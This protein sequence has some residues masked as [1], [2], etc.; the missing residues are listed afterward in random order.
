MSYNSIDVQTAVAQTGTA[1][2]EISRSEPLTIAAPL[3]IILATYVLFYEGLLWSIGTDGW[4]GIRSQLPLLDKLAESAGAYTHYEIDPE[5]ETVGVLELD[6]DEAIDVFQEDHGY[7]DGPVAA[8]K[9]LPDGR[10]EAASLV[11]YGF[12]KYDI[13]FDA[14]VIEGM[15]PGI[16]FLVILLIP[17]QRHATLFPGEEPGE[18]LVTAH[19]EYS[20][21]SVFFAY[22]HLIA[23]G[24]DIDRGVREVTDELKEHDR[25]EATSR[26]KDLWLEWLK[27]PQ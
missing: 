9:G 24:M 16:R 8:H 22:W 10:Q 4:R 19:Q 6:V 17:R 26:A 1:L 20:A 25:F 12:E 15:P 21:H 27:A 3:F 7:L 14:E 13:W 2:D 18:T 5:R 23:K 11:K